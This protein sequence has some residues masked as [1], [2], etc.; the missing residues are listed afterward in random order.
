ME[1]ATYWQIG[2][3]AVISSD[4]NAAPIVAGA[5]GGS[6]RGRVLQVSL[7]KLGP[8]PFATVGR[9]FGLQ[10]FGLGIDRLDHFVNKPPQRT[11]WMSVPHVTKRRGETG[12]VILNSLG[13]PLPV[14]LGCRH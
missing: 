11:R 10:S 13:Q 12:G 2:L 7:L 4:Q 14:A 8:P 1:G 9:S 5:R 3:Y 6:C